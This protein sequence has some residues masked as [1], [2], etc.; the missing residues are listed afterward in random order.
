MRV[1]AIEDRAI[2]PREIGA[3]HA[4]G[5]RVGDEVGFVALVEGLNQCDRLTGRACGPQRLTAPLGVLGDHGVG[6]RE[7]I[8]RRAVILLQTYNARPGEGTLEVEDV[9]DIGAAPPVNGLVVVADHHHVAIASAHELHETELRGVGVL[10]FVYQHILEATLVVRPQRLVLL[11]RTDR[12]HE[13]IVE[14]DGIGLLQRV[15]EIG[16]DAGDGGG[17]RVAGGAGIFA[18]RHERILGAGDRAQ[19]RLRRELRGAELATLHD[20]LDGTDGVVF[21]VDREVLFAS[22]NGRDAAQHAR[23]QGVEGAAPHALRFVTEELGDARPHLAGR[24]VGER[25]RQDLV[26]RHAAITDEPGDARGQ[27]SGFA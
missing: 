22:H 19:D 5:D 4:R 27:D 11:E 26:G 9:P 7:D 16:V 24:L 25:D 18:G 14:G 10:I 6:E 8:G 21:V 17:E 15:F 12:E 2:A 13:Q 1:G 20:A 23:A 3:R